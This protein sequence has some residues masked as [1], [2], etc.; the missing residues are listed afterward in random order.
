MRDYIGAIKASGLTI[1][2]PIEV[3]DPALWIPTPE[4]EVL[5]N[6]GMSGIS[7]A[8][9]AIRTRSK[10][11]K[12]HVCRVLGYPVPARFRKLQPRFAGQ[13]FDTYVQKA[14]NLQIWNE[15]L[16]STRRYVMIRVDEADVVTRVKVVTGEDLAVLDTTGT[17]TQKYQARL[18]PGDADAE[19]IADT[20]SERL[21][22]FV[23][24]GAI[25]A[26]SVSPIDHPHAASI[27]PIA[28][29]FERLSPL[30]GRSFRDAGRDQ[31]RNRG[32]A[33]HELVCLSSWVIPA[34]RTT[35]G[36]RTSD[37]SCWR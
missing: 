1:D 2:D 36:F 17:L 25:P 19:L 18:V 34:I 11:A 12:Q 23:R 15:G 28:E 5:L 21:Q 16:S 7:L 37:T 13:R 3:G 27:L 10:V 6:H 33:L 8:G 30:L 31:D 35:V 29:I 32:A 22:P 14:N 9:L 4:L 26:K 20:D 24:A